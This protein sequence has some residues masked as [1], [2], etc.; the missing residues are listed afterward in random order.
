MLGVRVAV[1]GEHLQESQG[2]H[3]RLFGVGARL[4]DKRAAASR[5]LDDVFVGVESRDEFAG[6]VVELPQGETFVRSARHVQTS[7]TFAAR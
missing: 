7:P 3:F 1:G 5:Y 4:R 2:E 6:Q